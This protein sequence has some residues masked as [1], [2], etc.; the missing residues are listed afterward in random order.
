MPAYVTHQLRKQSDNQGWAL[1][2]DALTACGRSV[3]TYMPGV[4]WW[5]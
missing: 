3:I 5:T 1:I 2:A 4:I